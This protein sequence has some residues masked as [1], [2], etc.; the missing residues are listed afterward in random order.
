M[1]FT[2]VLLSFTLTP[3]LSFTSHSRI[4]RRS[5]IYSARRDAE[6]APEASPPVNFS[7]YR[8]PIIPFDLAGQW[9]T[10]DYQ[11]QV[12][13]EKVCAAPE[14]A[15]VVELPSVVQFDSDFNMEIDEKLLLS[16]SSKNHFK[17]RPKLSSERVL[18]LKEALEKPEEPRHTDLFQALLARDHGAVVDLLDREPHQLERVDF[19]HFDIPE[20]SIPLLVAI[21]LGLP[22]Q[23]LRLMLDKTP[24]KTLAQVNSAGAS[25]LSLALARR[26][27]KP[28]L[29][30]LIDKTPVEALTTRRGYEESVLL[31]ALLSAAD[32]E[33]ISA[34]IE[35]VP[36]E[37]AGPLL[38]LAIDHRLPVGLMRRL[39]SR[40]GV[41]DI[42]QAASRGMHK[43]NVPS[44]YMCLLAEADLPLGPAP[45]TEDRG[46]S[47]W[48][49]LLAHPGDVNFE[50][51]KLI[52]RRN[53]G[54]VGQLAV[55]EDADGRI[56][57][58]MAS[59]RVRDEMSKYL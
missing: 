12:Q 19:A 35:R 34:L 43:N 47:V 28:L 21:S 31:V 45:A 44:E 11:L 32:A 27:P 8:P 59:K 20:G 50:A 13:E 41:E 22:P 40:A 53:A 7:Q 3:S 10:E 52:L 14:P 25:A 37:D 16:A 29:L 39:I 38:M 26:M 33:V 24:R 9:E 18:E 51:I 57:F 5:R 23:L 58:G 48:H 30:E 17:N 54:V 4:C 42:R 2:L 49:M 1:L 6:N 55:S 46:Y 56:S 15:L 36:R